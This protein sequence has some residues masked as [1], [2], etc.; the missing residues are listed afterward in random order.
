MSLI[1]GLADSTMLRSIRHPAR[2]L[3]PPPTSPTLISDTRPLAQ[4]K[5]D[6]LSALLPLFSPAAKEPQP[7]TPAPIRRPRLPRALARK[8]VL[9]VF[10]AVLTF[11]TFI[12]PHPLGPTDTRAYAD[13][14]VTITNA[15]SNGQQLSRFDVDGNSL[16]A[17]DGSVLQV[18]GLYYLYGT[19][20]AC[21]YEYGGNSNFCG[22]KAYSSPDLVNWTDR[23]FVVPPHVCSDCFRPHVLYNAATQKFVLWSDGGGGVYNIYTSST[24]SG[25][26]TQAPSPKLAVGGAVDLALFQDD[27][28]DAYLIHN[29]TQVAAGLTA[30]GVVEK[31]TPDYLSVTGQHTNFGLGDVEAFTV[32]KRNGVYHALM[33]DPTCAYCSGGTGEMTATSMLGPWS[34]AWYD[35]NGVHQSGRAEPRWRARIVNGT[36]CGGQPL[37]SFPTTLADGS[38]RYLFMSDRWDSRRA[39]ESTANLFIGPMDFDSSGALQQIACVDSFTLNLPGSAG[40]PGTPPTQD[41]SSGSA[42]FRHYCDIAGNVQR[43]QTFVPSRSGTLNSASITAFSWH[44]NAPLIVDLLDTVNGSTLSSQVLPQPPSA[45]HVMTVHPLIRVTAGHSY[46]LRMRS[47]TSS[48]CYGFEY[49]DANP[50][51]SGTESYSTNGGGAFT[52]ESARDLKFTTSVGDTDLLAPTDLPA[53]YSWCASEGGT[54]S[55]SG[56]ILIAY[57]AGSYLFKTATGSVI[58]GVSTFSGDPTP[59]VLKSCYVAPSG[60][61]DSYTPCASENGYCSFSGTHVIAYGANGA[62]TYETATNGKSC[63]YVSFGGDPLYGVHKSCYL[64]PSGAPAGGWAT[65]APE[66]GTCS[67]ADAQVVAFGAAGSF[68]ARQGSAACTV[69][70]FGIDPAPGAG[71]SCYTQSGAP[72]GYAASC[73]PEK[74]TCT[75]TGFRTVAYGAAG[76]FAYRSFT[77]QAPCNSASFGGDPI[78]GVVKACYL[79]P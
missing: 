16:D 71:K 79:T 18:G 25:Q 74:G 72:V 5:T 54:C 57:G 11:V 15:D 7:M 77:A 49:N 34:G 76:R 35:P 33:S 4:Q 46:T 56:T 75:F 37:A 24:P 47:A 19:S 31:L 2:A 21:G 59:G 20:Y 14:G 65:C 52:A 29:T 27:N 44:T 63:D 6:C 61:P 12:A 28:G 3:R 55:V 13:A 30:D 23:G 26:F 32:F 67:A 73:A 60:G 10:A 8:A 40:A 9:T 70:A 51:A 1:D 22:F 41:Q 78:F 53:G 68:I 64:A 62:F 45:P 50:Y 17:H 42:G 58:C 38:T 66:N 48:G 39:N 43:Q 36:S 69:A